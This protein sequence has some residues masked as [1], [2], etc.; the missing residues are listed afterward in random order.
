MF[1][2]EVE[3]KVKLNKALFYTIFPPR[4]VNNIYFD[5]FYKKNYIE[6][7]NGM[8]VREKV[9]VRWYGNLF[10]S[11]SDP[12]I[13]IKH[14][15][16][17]INWKESYPLKSFTVNTLIAKS[18]LDDVFDKSNLPDLLN[19]KL[20]A[21]EPVFINRY[22]RKYFLSADGQFRITIDNLMEYYSFN[23]ITNSFINSNKNFDDIIL[24]LKCG[25]QSETESWRV[26]NSLPFRLTKSSKYLM[27]VE[28]L[29]LY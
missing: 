23:L 7:V 22:Y 29:A 5:T 3:S 13:E 10:Q 16:Q 11:I 15:R 9:R 17:T 8:S 14:R 28:S 4:Y 20:A 21:L 24:E 12:T 18:G 6:N 26:T 25:T 27:G 2:Y 1:D 19:E